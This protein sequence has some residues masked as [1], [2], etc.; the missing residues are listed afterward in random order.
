MA[1]EVCANKP[2]GYSCDMYS[3]A[4]MLWEMLSCNRPFSGYSQKMHHENVVIK[5][6]R[7]K[8]DENWG[9]AMKGF[10]NSCWNQ[11]LNKRP[12]AAKAS[13]ILKREAAKVSGGAASLELNNF[14]RKSTFVN[15]DSLRESR[16]SSLESAQ[17]IAT[18][19]REAL[20]DTSD[21]SGDGGQ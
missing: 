7:P 1:P 9:P 4:I 17:Q 14:R 10:L 11:D 5:G 13:A 19:M 6:G 3:F 8:V 20:Q 16:M 18:S 21:R 2:Y 12:T 15:R